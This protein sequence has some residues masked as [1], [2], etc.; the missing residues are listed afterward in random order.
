MLGA[1]ELCW[2]AQH[3]VPGYRDD[4]ALWAREWRRVEREPDATVLTGASRTFFDVQVPVWEK[5]SGRRPV[6]LAIDGTAPTFVVERLAATPAF[7]GRVLIGV[8]PDVFFT[9]FEYR[10][11]WNEYATKQ[12]PSERV[13]KWLSMQ[14]IE[15]T[16]AFY[17]PDFALFT[18]LAR[19]PWPERPGRPVGLRVRKLTVLDS[20]RNG[21]MWD[22]LV[23]DPE[24]RELARRTWA[25]DFDDPTPEVLADWRK[26]EDRTVARMVRAVATLRARGV[27][28]VFVREPSVDEY[29]RF[30]EKWWPRARWDALLARTGAPGV[31]FQDHATLR[32]GYELPEWSH[33]SHASAE[34]YTHAL[35]ELLSERYPAPDGHW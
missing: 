33:M 14:L 12:S 9:G 13:G 31:H 7:R 25:V 4:E 1:W 32:D 20:P 34:R 8:A 24:Y 22:R 11:T 17:D 19:Q 23:V 21:R 16:F 5:L 3:A 2:R 15:P 28:V 35:F 26:A 27:H 18:V 10:Q 6:Q 29:L 30:E